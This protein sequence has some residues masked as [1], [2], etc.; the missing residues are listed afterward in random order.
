[1]KYTESA[2]IRVQ[3]FVVKLDRHLLQ[4]AP[5]GLV[6]LSDFLRFFNN[7]ELLRLELVELFSLPARFQ[8]LAQLL[9]LLRP[10]VSQLLDLLLQFLPLF[11]S[12]HLGLPRGNRARVVFVLRPHAKS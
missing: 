5:R 4:L 8:H 3:I 12:L 11:L 1:M 9:A 2:I 6:P 10:F 7:L